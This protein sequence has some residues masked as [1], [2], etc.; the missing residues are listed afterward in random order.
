MLFFRLRMN[1]FGSNSS[2]FGDPE[3]A[4]LELVR[5]CLSISF[6][7]EP[8]TAMKCEGQSELD[9]HVFAFTSFLDELSPKTRS[10]YILKFTDRLLNTLKTELLSDGTYKI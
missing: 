8:S 9:R 2:S 7:P 4:I 1:Q 5:H 3:R 10:F 6:N